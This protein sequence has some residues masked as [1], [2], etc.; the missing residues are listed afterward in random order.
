MGNFNE[1]VRAIEQRIKDGIAAHEKALAE[2]Q[3]AFNALTPEQQMSEQLRKWQ[4]LLEKE[5]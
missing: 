5:P 1:A 4:S 3:A 2:A